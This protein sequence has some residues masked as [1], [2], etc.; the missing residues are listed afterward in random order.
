MM[1]FDLG[2]RK[3]HGHHDDDSGH[4]GVYYGDGGGA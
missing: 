2:R 3:D 4:A 1:M